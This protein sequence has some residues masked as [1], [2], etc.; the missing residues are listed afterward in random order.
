MS[1]F[2]RSNLNPNDVAPAVQN[3]ADILARAQSAVATAIFFDDVAQS[4]VAGALALA[5][6]QRGALWLRTREVDNLSLALGSS[7]S[8]TES[9]RALRE[10]TCVLLQEVGGNGAAKVHWLDAATIEASKAS[11]TGTEAELAPDGDF[12]SVI[13]KAARGETVFDNANAAIP[14]LK[15]GVVIAVLQLNGHETQHDQSQKRD[16]ENRVLDLDAFETFARSAALGLTRARL[17]E[18]IESA[19]CEWETAFDGMVDGVLIES[20]DGTILRANLIAAAFYGCEVSQV[21]GRTSEE[22]CARLADYQQLRVLKPLKGDASGRDVRTGEFR[23]GTPA[24]IILETV[25]ALR[26]S[27]YRSGRARPATRDASTMHDAS[28]KRDNAENSAERPW[29]R[30][31][32]RRTAK[33]RTTER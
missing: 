23:F 24:R 17:F 16:A 3:A 19:K 32:W 30:T 14:L 11:Q 25:S 7:A 22:L 9:A 2:P 15:D 27:P 5:N 10:W 13:E 12:A 1:L 18:Q 21:V 26:L 33:R 20:E 28:T 31:D 6:A 8:E 4:V 29:K